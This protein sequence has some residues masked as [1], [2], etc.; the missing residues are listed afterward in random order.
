MRLPASREVAA[1]TNALRLQPLVAETSIEGASPQLS[2][3]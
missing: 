2:K 3:N 1:H